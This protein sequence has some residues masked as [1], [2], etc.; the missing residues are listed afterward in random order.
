MKKISIFLI[1][2]CLVAGTLP[3][4][5]LA[6]GSGAEYVDFVKGSIDDNLVVNFTDSFWHANT[7]ND[8]R[9]ALTGINWKNANPSEDWPGGY[10]G[11]SMT[12]KEDIPT[13][14]AHYG[15][16]GMAISTSTNETYPKI[17]KAADS[18][19]IGEHYVFI[20][21][22]RNIN[23]DVPA[24]IRVGVFNGTYSGVA[25]KDF[26]PVTQYEDGIIELP[27]SGEWITIKTIL[28]VSPNRAV[29]G[30]RMGFA[31]GTQ[32]GAAVEFNSRHPGIQQAYYAKETA[33]DIQ[34]DIVSGE[35]T[36][37]V[38]ASVTLSAAV[39][40]QLEEKGNLSQE[41]DWVL[42]DSD[43]N[44]VEEGYAITNSDSSA[45]VTFTNKGLENGNYT[46]VA[47][48]KEYGISRFV[49]ISIRAKYEYSDY[50]VI[51]A[52]DNLIQTPTK[53]S[54]V[55]SGTS[56]IVHG[57]TDGLTYP[58]VY[59]WYVS[60]DV[61]SAPDNC[62]NHGFLYKK[63]TPEGGYVAGDKYL[64]SVWVRN[65]GEIETNVVVG[66]SNGYDIGTTYG[67][68]YGAEGMRVPADGK[69]HQYKEI[70]TIQGTNPL[71]GFGFSVGTKSG[72]AVEINLTKAELS[73]SY[74]AKEK[75]YDI[76]LT[77]TAPAVSN[78]GL[79]TLEAS[80]VNQ[81]GDEGTL[82]QNFTWDVLDE[83]KNYKTTGYT[84]TPN[85]DTAT[86]SVDTTEAENIYV[87]AKSTDYN[88]VR[89]FPVSVNG[90]K[91]LTDYVKGD[92]PPNLI[93][94]PT[95]EDNFA[96]ASGNYN[97]ESTG[98][99][100]LELSSTFT[101]KA[102]VESYSAK[103]TKASGFLIKTG[104]TG[105]DVDPLLTGGTSYVFSA[106]VKNANGTGDI[107]LDV[108]MSNSSYLDAAKPVETSTGYTIP[109][110]DDWYKVAATMKLPGNAGEGYKPYIIF[111]FG[112][113]TEAGDK[114]ELNRKYPGADAMY[115]APEKAHDIT[116]TNL[117]GSMTVEKGSDISFTANVLN[118][119]GSTGYLNQN[120]TWYVRKADNTDASSYFTFE[121]SEDTKTITLTPK[122]RAKGG[123]Y[124]VIAASDDYN[125]L[126]RFEDFFVADNTTTLYVSTEGSD[127]ADGTASEP[128]GSLQ[129]AID[130]I[131]ELKKENVTVNEVVFLPGEYRFAEGAVFDRGDVYD[132]PV[133]FRAQQKGTVVFKASQKLDA[134]DFK[135][136]T[137]INVTSR[138]APGMEGKIYSLDLAEAGY[139][140]ED[141][142]D[143]TAINGQ[144]GLTDA[145]EFNTLYYGGIEQTVSRWPDSGYAIKGDG[146]QYNSNS[147]NSKDGL[148]FTYYRSD[149]DLML[150]SINCDRWGD[151]KNFWIAS[152]EPYDYSKFRYYVKSIDT[153]AHTITICDNPAQKLANERSGRWQAFNL[154]EEITLPGEYAI[155]TENMMLYYYPQGAL[156]TCDIEFS[157]LSGAM[158]SIANCKNIIF[159]S[160]V[161]TQT[162][163][164]AITM[165]DVSDITIQN[166]DFTNIASTAVQTSGSQY[167]VS[168]RDS[169]QAQRKNGAYNVVVKG[170][171]F[172]NIGQT[173]IQLSGSGD[174]DTL[175]DSGNLIEDN[176]IN[177]TSNKAF[178]EA[179]VLGGCGVT[180]R[181]NNI[182]SVPM[183]AIRAWG[184]NHLIEYNE[185]YDVLTED[186]DCGAIYWGGSSI[187]QG[188]VVRYNYIHDT[189]GTVSGG[190]VG[191]YWDDM[192]L[193]QTAKYNILANQDIDFNSNG[194]GATVHHYNTTYVANKHL[195]HHDHA[196]RGEDTITRDLNY[197]SLEAIRNDILDL[198]LYYE[199]YP[200]L[201]S[202]IGEGNNPTKYTSIKGNL[203]VDVGGVYLQ[204]NAP[205][206]AVIDGNTQ[207]ESTDAFAD[208]DAQDF[209]LDADSELAKANPHIL[210]TENFDIE[211]IG[212][213]R[214]FEL[215]DFSAT[216]PA[217]GEYIP[218]YMSAV[219]LSWN[220]A[221]GANRY[222]V[223]VA[224][225]S[226]LTDVVYEDTIMYSNVTL[227][228]LSAGTYYWSVTAVNTSREFAGTK[229]VTGG[230]RR[231]VV[232]S[233]PADVTIT[234]P[235]VTDSETDS[236]DFRLTYNG[237]DTLTFNV[238]VAGYLEDGKL[239]FANIH[240]IEN[241]S[242]GD[243]FDI[244]S[245]VKDGKLA[246]CTIF[247]I[248]TWKD[249]LVPLTG[250]FINFTK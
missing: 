194:A 96:D 65:A 249:A 119:I 244:E 189:V 51:P 208:I 109:A 20:F 115:F 69:W 237:F 157:T 110:G 90:K 33:H 239:A 76:T 14:P 16:A 243:S 36:L 21:A 197:T 113:G 40:N 225:D 229:S 165:T 245:E 23:P 242:E 213:L 31:A 130:K 180:V 25:S 52:D 78:G 30:L 227:T 206:Y 38:N 246:G 104:G 178:W 81:L 118:Q 195:N 170:N 248:F 120:F 91:V 181:G 34:A 105:I 193:G 63:Y 184:N 116:V 54:L 9:V 127:S 10:L 221:A 140:P 209:R 129:G 241:A 112:I 88:I 55:S 198:D 219:T 217:Q 100:R 46:I 190:Q 41:F 172:V 214:D 132:V 28:P 49:P 230:V 89:M 146:E 93:A 135:L 216:Y 212:L 188:T 102:D 160:I 103:H 179:I 158:I 183:Q 207:L 187:Y 231:F 204:N 44:V 37:G 147:V 138:F 94:D 13:V 122:A 48:S 200:Y 226:A 139:T 22:A 210:N 152:F 151:A 175:T 218:P 17:E 250:G 66:L 148:S 8:S 205:K 155:D 6:S 121:I 136:V 191:I 176:Y 238:Y 80:V 144:Y 167:A 19:T 143:V 4:G 162:R 199:R 64:Y 153:V 32:K 5:V 86:L 149:I 192:Q 185:I 117:S 131:A 3:T 27:Q 26:I 35:N 111:G 228:G 196:Y 98:D 106:D 223:V 39:Y 173:A 85:G 99:Y 134:T 60:A 186:A 164:D 171:N 84:L 154:I 95:L 142:T 1:V 57:V 67:P 71:L 123:K 101:A 18:Y 236:I 62:Y 203:A 59:K 166:C 70:L 168:G 211:K 83:N 128:L 77:S 29:P 156:G 58:E 42:L 124:T 56:K 145:G 45:N 222:S 92:M 79:L 61:E 235:V 150:P 161:F 201:K 82:S 107:T 7:L 232:S 224:R 74:F 174:V 163:D 11:A 141:I 215:G 43:K 97:V 68:N 2:L 137:D 159:D 234:T 114:F 125:E 50:E 169:W 24:K 75:V 87:V 53:T 182:S 73:P 72:S 108:S 247:K 177:D 233:A 12:A 15:S 202:V 133:T 220:K 240:K 126:V 47:T